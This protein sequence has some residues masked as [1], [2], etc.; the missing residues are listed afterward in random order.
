MPHEPRSFPIGT[1]P[2]VFI[3]TTF[4]RL[5]SDFCSRTHHL[6]TMHHVTDD[7]RRQTQHCS[8]VRSTKI[9]VDLTG[10]GS[11]FQLS[12]FTFSSGVG[13]KNKI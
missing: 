12:F 2:I 4:Y 5:P 13:T 1:I 7:D 10:N 6:A 3:Y 8:I 9:N 11:G